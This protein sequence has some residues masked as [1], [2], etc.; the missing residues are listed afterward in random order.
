MAAERCTTGRDGVAVKPD[1]LAV[2]VANF[3]YLVP[4]VA[5][6]LVGGGAELDD[7]LQEGRLGLITAFTHKNEVPSTS[8]PAFA[9]VCIRNAVRAAAKRARARARWD[10]ACSFDA[11]NGDG[12]TFHELFGTEPTQE[13]RC[14]LARLRHVVAQL[15]DRQRAI[16]DAVAD[17]CT[18]EEIGKRLNLTG[19]RVRQIAGETIEGLVR[20]HAPSQTPAPA[21]VRKVAKK[22]NRGS[23]PRRLLEYKGRRLTKAQWARESGVSYMTLCRRLDDGWDLARALE[24]VAVR[25]RPARAA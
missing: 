16:L 3:E 5:R 9:T 15:P 8:F 13:A 20:R 24:T 1:A 23:K 6:R 10:R 12:R 22:V 7:L 11:E 25:G 2:S 17:G 14:T 4:R 18:F 21:A 19:C